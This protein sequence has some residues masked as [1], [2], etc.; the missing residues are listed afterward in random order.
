MVERNL[1]KVEV[2]SSRLFSR[3]RIQRRPSSPV[4]VEHNRPAQQ[5]YYTYW[6][7]SK[8]V[9]QRPAKPSRRVRL[10]SSPP[11]HRKNRPRGD[12]FVS[13][14][15]ASSSSARAQAMRPL[16][17]NAH[18]STTKEGL[19]GIRSAMPGV[20][21]SPAKVGHRPGWMW[22]RALRRRK[23]A[24]PAAG[25]PL[26]ARPAQGAQMMPCSP[27]ALISSLDSPPSVDR[28]SCVCC[29]SSGGAL[30]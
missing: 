8:A 1:A 18:A 30:P 23:R 9:M 16:H 28:M 15:L 14:S 3:S 2:E 4:D 27:S 10:P 6:R 25:L 29:P 24:A 11:E 20:A 21:M 12:F 17:P 13:G 22:T 5:S 26:T 19:V 7:G